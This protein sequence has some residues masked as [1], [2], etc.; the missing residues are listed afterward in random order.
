MISKGKERQLKYNLQVVPL[1]EDKKTTV[2]C[3]KI[4]LI[5]WWNYEPS[6]RYQLPEMGEITTSI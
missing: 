3:H 2:T 1:Q 6:S 5:H 4:M